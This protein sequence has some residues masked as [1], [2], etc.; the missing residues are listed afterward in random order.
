MVKSSSCSGAGFLVLGFMCRGGLLILIILK[1]DW[2]LLPD[3]GSD[4]VVIEVFLGLFL[5]H[6]F[7][8]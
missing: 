5:I 1:E 2:G 6:A 7:G 4:N 8:H 3:L